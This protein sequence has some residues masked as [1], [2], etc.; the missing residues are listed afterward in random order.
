METRV[1]AKPRDAEQGRQAAPKQ[2]TAA[3]ERLLWGEKW[4]EARK[5]AE[6]QKVEDRVVDALAARSISTSIKLGFCEE[7]GEMRKGLGLDEARSSAI[8]KAAA[9][10]ALE[11]VLLCKAV[12]EILGN[13]DI[14][15]DT[16]PEDIV[17][18]CGMSESEVAEAVGKASVTLAE[19]VKENLIRAR[20][21]LSEK[22]EASGNLASIVAAKLEES[23]N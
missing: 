13:N 17:E 22:E 19:R 9:K 5:L 6:E 20:R 15:R 1:L 18:K 4:E 23:Q 7:V 8:V 10:E 12:S 2:E 11:E 16:C 21:D 3:L 14:Y